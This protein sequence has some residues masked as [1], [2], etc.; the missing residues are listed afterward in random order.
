ME[1]LQKHGLADY[2]DNRIYV[3]GIGFSGAQFVVIKD[4]VV[5]FC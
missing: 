5:N 1:A 4:I 3:K 2:E